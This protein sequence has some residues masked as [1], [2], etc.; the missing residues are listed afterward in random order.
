MKTALLLTTALWCVPAFSQSAKTTAPTSSTTVAAPANAAAIA[1]TPLIMRGVNA[2]VQDALTGWPQVMAQFPGM[3]ALRL[4]SGAGDSMANISTVVQEYTGAGVIVEIEDHTGNPD[5]AQ[6]YTQLAQTFKGNPRVYLEMPNEPVADAST[7]ASNQIGIIKAIRSAGFTNPIG[8]QP[9]GGYD[10]SNLPAVIAAVGTT[11][12]FVTPHIYYS[13]TD[14]NGAVQYVQSD[15]QQAQALGLV[16]VIDEFGNAMDGVTL[17]P[18]GNAVILAVIAANEGSDGGTV[19]AGAIFWAM[20]NGNH[21]DGTD[22]AFLDPT[23]SQLTPVGQQMIQPWLYTANT[24]SP[25]VA[26]AAQAPEIAAAQQ[27]SRPQ[28]RRRHQGRSRQLQ[29]AAPETLSAAGQAATG[30]EHR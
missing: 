20:D 24:V 21:P 13:G 28:R 14:P 9:V 27:S 4:N 12:L 26:G 18:Q 16:A 30:A 19:Q 22:S 3:T 6:W 11:G 7:T 2:G 23:G 8:V 15:I 5:N 29:P 10:F 25:A 1:G 17:D